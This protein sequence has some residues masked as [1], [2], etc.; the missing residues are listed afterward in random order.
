MSNGVKTPQPL[1]QQVWEAVSRIKHDGHFI[2]ASQC[3][4]EGYSLYRANTLMLMELTGLGYDEAKDLAK[5]H[6]DKPISGVMADH[7]S[8][9]AFQ[10]LTASFAAVGKVYG[11]AFGGLAKAFEAFREGFAQGF[12]QMLDAADN[13]SQ[14][15]FAV[16][17]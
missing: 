17:A 6:P 12:R 4:T 15:D 7:Y 1:T 2:T 13:S 3:Q 8:P 9:E 14:D 10:D 11:E 16:T 5:S